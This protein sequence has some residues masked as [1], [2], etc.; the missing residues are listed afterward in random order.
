MR[1]LPGI[2]VSPESAYIVKDYPYGFRLRCIIR[3]WIE[4]RPKM[5]FRFCSQTSNP[6]KA[7]LV[8][9]KPKCSI[10]SRFGMAM[11][12]DDNTGYV[13]HH[14]LTEY[15]N[16]ADAATW[17]NSYREGIPESG[18]PIHDKWIKTKLAYDAA[19]AK[20]ESMK[21]NENND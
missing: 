11:G 9:N 14:G 1:I 13:I 2:H 7:G 3:Y 8:W 17:S 20:A 15:T 16:G 18:L 19:K 6:K 21:N 12:F 4:Y 10:Y 5:G